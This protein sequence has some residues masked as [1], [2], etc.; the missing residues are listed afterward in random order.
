MASEDRASRRLKF[1]GINDYGTYFQVESA[2]KI[3]EHYGPSSTPRTISDILELYN[4]H[5]FAESNLFPKTYPDRKREACQALI[6]ELRKT[7]AKFFDAINDANIA[8][9]VVD[10]G[11]VY[12]ADLLDLLSRYKVYHRCAATTVLLA[13]EKTHVGVGDMLTSQSLVRS[14]DQEVRARLVSNPRN[15]EHLELYS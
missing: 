6:P 8:S 3:L 13:L 14:Y 7:I 11:Y 10:V 1:H 2:V 9:V 12:H 4:A 15:A 5:L